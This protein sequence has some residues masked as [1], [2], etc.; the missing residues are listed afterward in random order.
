MLRE[1]VEI[2]K[3]MWTEPETTYEGEH[4]ELSR[5]QLRSQAAAGAAPADLDRRRRAS[6]SRCASSPATPTARTSAASPSSGRTSATCCKGHC[7]DVGRD[8]DEIRKTWSPE[9]FIRST[10]AEVEAAGSP[11]PVGRAVDSWR[12]G[13]LVGTP[14]QVSEK[15]RTYVDLGCAGFIPWCADYPDTETLE[16]F[17]D[18]R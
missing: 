7:A 12:A 4:Y 3:S 8:H 2:V 10:E 6:S 15:I 11:Q 16:L 13:N 17:A 14:E 9:M 18:A 5:R 1:T